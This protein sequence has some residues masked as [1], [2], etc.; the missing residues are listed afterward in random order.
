MQR[1][2][3]GATL[4]DVASEAGV[5]MATASRAINGRSHVSDA[6]RS[7]VLAAAERLNFTPNELAKSVISGWSGT[8]GV[9]TSDLE[10]RFMMPILTGLED[11]FGIEQLNIIVCN[12]RGDAIREQHLLK[13]LLS[14]RVDGIVVINRRTNPRP[15]VGRGLGVPV[16][17]A[18]GPSDDVSDYSIVPDDQ[19]GAELQVEHL[20][21][22]GRSNIAY[23]SGDPDFTAAGVRAKA[24]E[25]FLA[26]RNLELVVP[27][28]LSEWSESWGRDATAVL[29]Q[30]A[31][32][33]DA[34][35]CGSDRLARGVLDTLR[36]FG[37]EVPQQVAVIGYDNR[38]ELAIDARPG[39]TTIDA[40]LENLGREV[41][42]QL[43]G[44]IKGRQVEPGVRKL[45]VSLVIRGSTIAR[46]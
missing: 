19:L 14:R 2:D 44:L 5:S 41:A 16:I 36:D 25:E 26:D 46:R 27:P 11:A 35:A 45:P 34:I 15:S 12:A 21:S 3:K 28:L 39:L 40:R 20:L 32:E 7:R 22:C 1:N 43:Y 31:P 13:N 33:L 24:A 18:Y 29:L 42:L 23:V 8:V 38:E 37:V 4:A 6:S 10:G 17:Y 30:R 9:L